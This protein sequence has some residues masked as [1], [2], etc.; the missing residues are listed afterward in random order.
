MDRHSYGDYTGPI[1][2]FKDKNHADLAEFYRTAKTPH[3]QLA[4]GSGYKFAASVSS[5]LVARK[6]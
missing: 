3:Q 4:F 6:K 5:L 2:L 1:K